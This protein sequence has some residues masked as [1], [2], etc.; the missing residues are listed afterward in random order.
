MGITV[1][2]DT[3][4]ARSTGRIANPNAE[5]LF[6]GPVLRDFGFQY[7]M[8]ARSKEEGDHDSEKS[9]VGLNKVQHLNIE[10]KRY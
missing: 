8:I 3:L 1:E 6:Q 4:L 7:L 2:P 5:L 9:F 10:I